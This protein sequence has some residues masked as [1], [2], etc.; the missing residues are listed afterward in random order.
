[1]KKRIHIFFILF[2]F[3]GFINSFA[4]NGQAL[5][6]LAIDHMKSGR[7]GEAIDLL[8]N[9]ISSY[10]QEPEGYYLRGLCFEQRYQYENATLD[11]KRAVKLAKGT[12]KQK[13]LKDLERVTKVWYSQLEKKIQGHKREIAI[14][15]SNPV[16][17][18]EI[19]KAYKKMEKYDLA[20][21][22]Y[23]KYLAK[24]DNASPDEIIRYTEI[25]AKTKHIK[26][27]EKILKKYV[28]RYPDDWRL[29][30]RYG[31]F[32]LWLGKRK[33][34]IHAFQTA[35]SFKPYFKE[36]LD[37]LERAKNIP[38]VTQYQPNGGRKLT[39]IERLFAKVKANPK[40]K[41]TRLR[42]IKELIKKKR[43]EEAYQQ[44]ITLADLFPNDEQAQNK[45]AEVEAAR[46]K[47]YNSQIK[48]NLKIL[49]RNPRNTKALFKVVQ[50]YEN[51]QDYDSAIEL[52]KNYFEKH[53][54]SKNYNLKFKYAKLAAWNKEFDLAGQILDE[55]LQQ[56][57]NNIDYK[58]LRA[59]IYVW[60]NQNIDIAEQY[61]NS[62][63]KK[64][65]NDINALITMGSL[66]ILK[67]DP[68]EA[69][70]Y[71]DKAAKI[72]PN[73]DDL[74]ELQNQIDLLKQRLEQEKLLETLNE[75]RQLVMDSNCVDAI[76]YY[77]E[78][79]EK[80]QPN[81]LI[82]KE[83]GDVLFCAK[84]YD[85]ALE[86]YDEVLQNGY[87]YDAALQKAKVLFTMGDSLDALKTFKW[88]VKEDSAEFEPRLYLGDSYVK[89][90]KY[91]SALAVYDTLLT[92]D[93]DS[94]QRA[95]VEMRYDWV[96]ATGIKGF[97]KKF[98]TSISFAPNAA[99]YSDNIDF[100]MTDFGGRLD[101]GTLSWLNFGVG[102]HRFALKGKYNYRSFAL[103]NIGLYLTFNQHWT[104]SLSFG[105]LATSGYTSAND[106]E[107]SV[108]YKYEKKIE[109]SGYYI[110]RD[111]GLILYSP[112]LI[113]INQ[114]YYVSMYRLNW[115]YE[116]KSGFLIKGYFSYLSV[117]DGNAGNYFMFRLGKRFGEYTTA[118]YEYYFANF[119]Y[120]MSLYSNPNFENTGHH[121]YYS[122][123]EFITHS[124]WGEYKLQEGEQ[125]D[126]L[127]GG[128]FGYV[129][130]SAFLIFEGFG[131]VEYRPFKRLILT[132]QLNAGNSM[133]D[134][135]GY[136]SISGYISAYWN[137]YP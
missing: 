52:L 46:E 56:R 76:P 90:G 73:N 99:F 86:I 69:Q 113:N 97:L 11:L 57:P 70:K 77:E 2:L 9:Y 126:I 29:W 79:L 68:D 23:D 94:T 88:V 87:W 59:Q 103:F 1:M 12:K 117:T 65:P 33:T 51:L 66:E 127:V 64:R 89:V 24:D 31:T 91:D 40:D 43:Y 95:M 37:G 96:P 5:K 10:P 63:L 78:Y 110:R 14:D 130:S 60:S 124:I 114:R 62:V 133:R 38:Y 28:E 115:L 102:L 58:L 53:P 123:Q 134:I 129:P 19:G 22:W 132:A 128:K 15:P 42:L 74:N 81:D 45:L 4:Q 109:I 47:Y 85:K 49:K 36:A 41:K 108:K 112:G 136:R 6:Q 39:L 105:S 107:A 125:W 26:K 98:P 30:S 131:K 80:A 67:Q 48:R 27:G 93:L 137:F 116:H 7:Y 61:L 17:Y 34:A 32:T 71:A 106:Y 25:L 55:L 100:L 83:F 82:K 21:E 92:W 20:E 8:N 75:G 121:Y 50:Y 54:N 135:E 16:N 101:F 35:L 111:A 119:R 44:A 84:E 104:A 18:L 3:F 122:P 72:D 118:G 13:Y 120:D